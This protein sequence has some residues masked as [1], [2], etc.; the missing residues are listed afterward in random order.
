M[1]RFLVQ[2]FVSFN[3]FGLPTSQGSVATFSVVQKVITSLVFASNLSNVN[4]FVKFFHFVKEEEICNTR[5][6]V[7]SATP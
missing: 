7:Y 1:I 5:L 3:K 4:R 6:I 2:L